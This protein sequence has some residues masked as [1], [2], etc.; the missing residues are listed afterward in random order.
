MWLH[1]YVSFYVS[2][3]IEVW[4]YYQ[5]HVLSSSVPSTARQR[6]V[7]RCPICM[8]LLGGKD[9]VVILSA[10]WGRRM[11]KQGAAQINWLRWDAVSSWLEA[12]P[13]L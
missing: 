9:P 6:V 10:F 3:T 11:Q 2:I 4:Q 12:Q 5:M 7:I 8:V 13:F 1:D